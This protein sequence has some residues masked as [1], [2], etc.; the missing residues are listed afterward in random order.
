MDCAAELIFGESGVD[1][2]ARRLL[3]VSNSNRTNR[4][5]FQPDRWTAQARSTGSQLKGTS[6][7]T[8]TNDLRDIVHDG[9]NPQRAADNLTVSDSV[10]SAVGPTGK[11]AK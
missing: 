5:Y 2:L 1:I 3:Q 6:F 9:V 4:F 11:S 7:M 8:P 10:L